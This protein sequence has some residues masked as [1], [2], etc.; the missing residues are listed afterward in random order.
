MMC[1][2]RLSSPAAPTGRD[3]TVDGIVALAIEIADREGLTAVS[4]RRLASELAVTPMALYWHFSD[5]NHLLDSMAERVVAEAAFVDDPEEAWP[6]RYRQV[7]VSLVAM[8][9]V[10][11][12]ANRLVI[13]R[14]VPLPNYLAALEIMLDCLRV[15][16]F[17]TSL[18][19]LIAQ[20]SVQS[21]AALVEYEPGRTGWS[22]SDAEE[23]ARVVA[24]MT[25]LDGTV[26]PNVSAAV[27]PLTSPPDS[28]L[29][30]RLGVETNVRGVEALAESI[31]VCRSA[32]PAPCGS[33]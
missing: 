28:E 1:V 10:H 12:W 22:A 23:C 7:L 9:R 14:L 32:G 5:K 26:F 8:L 3:L 20:Q 33:S 31:G 29:Y 30:F 27:E 15:A 18:G 4:M 11:P 6:D 24:A 13:E 17:G 19:A 21:M 2:K 16:G 25:A